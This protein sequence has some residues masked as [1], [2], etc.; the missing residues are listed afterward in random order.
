MIKSFK[1][2]LTQM[3]DEGNTPKSIPVDIA[4][5]AAK[6][7]VMIGT[8]RDVRDLN[9]PIGNRLHQLNADHAGQWSITVNDK[10]RICFIWRDGNAYDVEFI[11]YH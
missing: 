6:K 10:W 1:N 7:L 5:R 9:I 8:A 3:I 4:R 11:D 2:R